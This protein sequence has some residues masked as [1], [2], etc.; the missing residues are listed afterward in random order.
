MHAFLFSKHVLIF[1]CYRFMHDELKNYRNKE[2]KLLERT[3]RAIRQRLRRD[4][5]HDM[6]FKLGLS[7][8]WEI[9]G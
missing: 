7:S 8:E 4:E 6:R 1:S 3:R 2:L 9:G 5:S